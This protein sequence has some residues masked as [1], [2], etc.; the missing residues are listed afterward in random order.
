LAIFKVAVDPENIT[1]LLAGSDKAVLARSTNAGNSWEPVT[2]PPSASTLKFS[3]IEFDPVD[4]QIVYAGTGTNRNPLDGQGL[5]RSLDGG[6]T[7][8]RFNNPPLSDRTGTYIQGIALDPT[9]NQTIF[10]TGSQGIFRSDNGGDS[11]RKQ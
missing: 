8:Q 1:N 10:I 6:Q 2:I 9:D 3:V 7:W 5:Y 4:P 11:W